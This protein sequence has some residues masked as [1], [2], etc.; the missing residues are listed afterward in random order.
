MIVD[1]DT[2]FVFFSSLIATEKEYF[3]FWQNLKKQLVDNNIVF[4]FIH[5]TRD[6]WCRDYMP[7]QISENKFVQF[8]YFPNYYLSPNYI[9]K[10]TIPA[11]INVAINGKVKNSR[12]IIDGG[13]IVN[14]STK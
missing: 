10:L 7:I 2:N 6:I 8:A 11:E 14:S 12:L 9:S 13:N 1:K 5:N 4:D 3:T